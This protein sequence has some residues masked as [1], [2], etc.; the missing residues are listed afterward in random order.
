MTIRTIG[1]V[2]GLVLG[3]AV[4]CDGKEQVALRRPGGRQS[5]CAARHR[6]GPG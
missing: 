6:T 4:G 3:L 1:L 2:A 5:S